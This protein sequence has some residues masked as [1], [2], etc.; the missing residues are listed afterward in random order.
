MGGGR[1]EVEKN[2][3]NELENS[4]TEATDTVT[5]S[6]HLSAISKEGEGRLEQ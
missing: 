3:L 2:S 1:K 6:H 5:I 4:H